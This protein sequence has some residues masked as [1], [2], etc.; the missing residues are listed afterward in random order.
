MPQRL[1]RVAGSVFTK[2]RLIEDGSP[3][4]KLANSLP[5]VAPEQLAFPA[6][7]AGVIGGE[8]ELAVSALVRV[9]QRCLQTTVVFTEN[10]GVLAQNL[11]VVVRDLV[12]VGDA[13]RICPTL[14]SRLRNVAGRDDRNVRWR[15]GTG[16]TLPFGIPSA[17]FS[18]V[19]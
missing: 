15:W 13:M 1:A 9:G 6:Q 3:S 10:E 8:I 12:D 17:V 7:A 16:C 4:R 14:R 11:G 19:W 5:P 2:P 18:L